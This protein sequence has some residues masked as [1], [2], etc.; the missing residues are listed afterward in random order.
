M[1][2]FIAGVVAGLV[3]ALAVIGGGTIVAVMYVTAKCLGDDPL[4]LIESARGN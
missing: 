2:V 4:P 3:L 1:G